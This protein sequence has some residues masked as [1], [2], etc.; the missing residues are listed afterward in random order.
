MFDLNARVHFQK[1]EILVFVDDELD[2]AGGEI[3]HRAGQGDRLLAHCPTR[4]GIDKG[5]RRLFDDLLVA[6]LDGAFALSQIK[7]IP[8]LVGEHLNFDMARFLDEFLDEDTIVGE[9][10]LRFVAGR[11]ETLARFL[12]VPGN[13][14]ALAAA[15]GGS[16][17]HHRIADLPGY[18]GSMI[19]RFDQ[20]HMTRHRADVRFLGQ[21]LRFDL[22]THG[23][24]G[25][26]GRADE[27]D[28]GFVERLDETCVFR[29]KS[30]TRVNGLRTAFLAGSDDLVDQ[31]VAFRGRRRPNANGLVRQF[32]VQ[33]TAVRLRENGYR[34]DAHFLGRA[35]DSA[36]DFAPVGD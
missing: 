12:V 15:A 31:Q 26:G 5:R 6:A 23:A 13:A 32:D 22:V 29:E 30:K 20:I 18:V 19:G 28:S 16:L 7:R 34:L 11:S 33:R 25:T 27:N 14:H 3:V 24:D 21:A 2:R 1:V 4:V 36:G 10:R 8:M 35:N 9:A 17:D